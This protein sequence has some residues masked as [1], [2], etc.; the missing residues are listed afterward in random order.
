MPNPTKGAKARECDGHERGVRHGEHDIEC[1]LRSAAEG[2]ENNDGY[3]TVTEAYAYTTR[4]I[5]LTFNVFTS[6]DFLPR[7][8]GG[9]VDFILF[10]TE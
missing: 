6:E 7:I 3:V 8:S 1:A 4:Q 10:N 9:P 2:D 5:D